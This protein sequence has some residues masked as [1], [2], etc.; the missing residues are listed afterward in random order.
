MSRETK[1]PDVLN[2]PR[3]T[4]LASQTRCVG[5]H[6]RSKQRGFT[7]IELLVVI[8][9]IAVLMGIL[10][11]TLGRVREQARQRSCASRVRQHMM[12]LHMYGDENDGKLPLPNNPFGW[13]WDIEVTTLNYMLGSG[14]NQDM[15]YCP[16]N[17]NQQKNLDFYWTWGVKG[18]WDGRRFTGSGF[19]CAGYCYLLELARGKRPDILN[20]ENKTGSKAWVKML[21]EKNAGTREVV[22]DVVMSEYRP[23]R[24]Y[25][26]AMI[27]VKGDGSEPPDQTSH[28]KTD[29]EPLGG[30]IG[31]L[32]GHVD[33]RHFR[34]MEE[35]YKTGTTFWW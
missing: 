8:A 12:A 13:L 14:L 5:C 35:R 34:D 10:L 30:N 9:I 3:P 27:D 16:S 15:F 29:D 31:F 4:I 25:N 19:A 6:Q 22:V 24:G 7:L 23:G 2:R 32:D 11:P 21:Q 17:A 1:Q 26:F 18:E 33:W 20:K 28:L